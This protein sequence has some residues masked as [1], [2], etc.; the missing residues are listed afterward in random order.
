M[1]M[2]F[3][4][5]WHV[6]HPFSFEFTARAL[7]AGMALTLCAG[8]APISVSAQTPASVTIAAVD[9]TLGCDIAP[10]SGQV[11][12]YGQ[13]VILTAPPYIERPNCAE[14]LVQT[15]AA[16][17]YRV[18]IEYAALESRPVRLLLN[19]TLVN[20]AAMVETTGCWTPECQRWVDVGTYSMPDGPVVLRLERDAAFAHIRTL[21]ITQISADAAP[22]GPAAG[23]TPPQGQAATGSPGANGW[24]V[25]PLTAEVLRRLRGVAGSAAPAASQG[26]GKQNKGDASGAAPNTGTAFSGAWIIRDAID[27]RPWTMISTQA[28]FGVTGYSIDPAGA[29]YYYSY[30]L[31][32]SERYPGSE[33]RRVIVADNGTEMM[34]M[35]FNTVTPDRI[36]SRISFA[37]S[38]VSFNLLE[39][40]ACDLRFA[41]NDETPMAGCRWQPAFGFVLDEAW[42]SGNCAYGLACFFLVPSEL[43]RSE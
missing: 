12:L 42:L 13:G 22:R 7:S 21:R 34:T 14:Y 32:L 6:A 25:S 4:E 1:W 30:D 15:P 39:R 35:E 11:A 18:E 28:P 26:V 19:G 2:A 43:Y 16:G 40:T 36:E 5:Y 8:L 24:Q 9:Y 29:R 3:Q 10:A 41:D 27:G 33:P 23:G 31:E 37:D 38:E 17:T 20:M